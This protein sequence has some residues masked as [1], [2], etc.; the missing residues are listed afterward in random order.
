[1]L[2][3]GSAPVMFISSARVP[4]APGTLRGLWGRL[5]TRLRKC[6]RFPGLLLSSDAWSLTQG[7]SPDTIPETLRPLC[8]DLGFHSPAR[9]CPGLQGREGS[10]AD[11]HWPLCAWPAFTCEDALWPGP[12][13]GLIHGMV[14]SPGSLPS[15]S[16]VPG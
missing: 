5:G 11:S 8:S 2:G 9:S 10:N 6:R 14:R 16:G 4:V 13:I 12:D 7:V 3:A 15:W 1:M